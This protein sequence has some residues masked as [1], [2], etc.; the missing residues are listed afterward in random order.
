MKKA[1]YPTQALISI[2]ATRY[3]EFGKPISCAQVIAA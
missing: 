1:G 3:T 2:G